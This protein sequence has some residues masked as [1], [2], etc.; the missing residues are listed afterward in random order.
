VL[1]TYPG[2]GWNP[3]IPQTSTWLYDMMQHQIYMLVDQYDMAKPILQSLYGHG[4]CTLWYNAYLT[5]NLTIILLS[6]FYSSDSWI[7]VDT[8]GTMINVQETQTYSMLTLSEGHI[9]VHQ[10]VK[11][12][13]NKLIAAVQIPSIQNEWLSCSLTKD[14][15]TLW[16]VLAVDYGTSDFCNSPSRQG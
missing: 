8:Y 9:S 7:P 13:C 1:T 12:L 2:P 10:D 4:T 3:L 5:W 11:W 15:W 14:W 16:L 6:Y